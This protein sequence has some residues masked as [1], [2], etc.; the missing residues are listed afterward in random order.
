MTNSIPTRSRALLASV[1]L[2][3]GCEGGDGS[4]A[5]PQQVDGGNLPSGGSVAYGGS[6]DSVA[7]GGSG[8][9][10]AHGPHG[11]HTAVDPDAGGAGATGPS[12]RPHPSYPSLDLDGLPAPH[13]AASGPYTSPT[14]P[15]TTRT[16]TVT[17]HGAEARAD[18]LSACE[19]PGTAVTVPDGAGN[20]GVVDFG[21]VEDCDVTLGAE[22]V[23]SLMYV[24]H[25]PGPV[26]APA[27]RIRIRG[28]QIGAIMVDP[29]STDIVFDGVV[30]NN[31]V[32]PEA[33]RGGTGIYL[34]STGGDIVNRFAFV[35]SILR[36]VATAPTDAGDTD[37][38]AYL[39]SNARNVLFAGN[40]IIT[41]GNRN[42]WGFRISGGDNHLFIDNVV[43]VSFHKLIRMNDASV[44]YV[45]VRGGVWMREAGLT[46][47]GLELNDA[48]AQL[49][50][51]GTDNVFIH[52]TAV[53]LLSTEPVSFGASSGPG[54]VGKRWEA[55]GI[56]WYAANDSVISDARLSTL[57]NACAEGAICDYGVGTHGYHYGALT[58]PDAPWLS[59]PAVDVGDPDDLP[60]SSP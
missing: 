52:E 53:H 48:F 12:G 41:A 46:A 43:R 29:G 18:L 50:D 9:S 47:G 22:V 32:Q 26:V 44:D 11:G 17:T 13:G 21:H 3:V 54:Q 31:G 39:A 37:G 45:V 51:D 38:C 56:H 59:L 40:N 15:T 35:N 6:G 33:S 7:Y 36:M 57:A 60:I 28:G 42:S 30:L 58:L 34:I 1:F 49:G 5:A 55:R 14:L 4:A 23:V 20:L 19:V 16:V 25:L 27:H 10:M 24:G 2:L 8:G